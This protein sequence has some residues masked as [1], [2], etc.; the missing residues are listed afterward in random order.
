MTAPT[1][2]RVAALEGQSGVTAHRLD[3]ID[4]Q[5]G[6]MRETMTRIFDKLDNI[7]RLQETDAR[8]AEAIATAMGEIAALRR[9]AKEDAQVSQSRW[10]AQATLS[11]DRCRRIDMQHQT[12]R[13]QIDD[14]IH[15]IN[16]KLAW[17]TGMLAAI[18][19]AA[20]VVGVFYVRN[21]DDMS[22]TDKAQWA[23]LAA[24]EKDMR[25]LSQRLQAI[26]TWAS[27]KR[28]MP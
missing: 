18:Q 17:A 27:D 3:S 26:E 25:A 24:T 15:R 19:V 16:L 2:D 10:D 28:D 20:S 4:A 14:D 8:H 7:T 23:E 6:S 5:L 21:L 1:E 22:Q 13:R 11:A 12:A 9:D